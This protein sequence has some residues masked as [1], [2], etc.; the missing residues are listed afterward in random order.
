MRA[1][2]TASRYNG[3]RRMPPRDLATRLRP[4]LDAGLMGHVPKPFQIRQ[5]ELVMFPYVISSEATDESR[6]T[7]TLYG[8]P[9]ARQLIILAMVGRDHLDPGCSLGAR[10]ESIATHLLTTHHLGMPVFDLQLLHTHP[11]GLP[12]LRAVITDHLAR[13]SDAARRRARWIGRI[14]KDP[15]GYHRLFLGDDG[16]IARAERMEYPAPD[17]EG[18]GLPPEFFSLAAFLEHCATTYP[19]TVAELGWRR[20]PGHLAHLAG[21][22]R[23][24]GRTI[25]LGVA[26]A[27]LPRPADDA[28]Q[29]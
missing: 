23:R 25:S 13:S 24:E 4:F 17:A 22:H 18:S 11:D 21:R 16:Y 8:H 29:P 12:R 7:R 14:L 19:R 6:Y 20:L 27:A 9:L 3:P 28:A 15:D 1:T 2:L 5:G 10:F 26:R